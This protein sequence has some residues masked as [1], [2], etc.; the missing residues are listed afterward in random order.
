MKTAIAIATLLAFAGVATPASSQGNAATAR[1]AANAKLAGTWEGN[2]T[3]DGPSG[4]MTITLSKS[5]DWKVTCSLT[6]DAPPPGDPREL[7]IDGDKV[8]W[9]QTFGEYD[10][11]FKATLSAD[12]SQVTGTLEAT[13]SGSVVGG[14][15]FTLTRKAN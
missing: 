13:Q 6:G 10:V 4:I 8:T 14:G 15:S 1:A 12:A 2:Y 11:A 9:K 5:A 3:T 7:A